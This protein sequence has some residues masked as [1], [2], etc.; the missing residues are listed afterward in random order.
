MF[1]I[2]NGAPSPLSPAEIAE[3]QAPNTLAAAK[4]DRLA[5][6]ADTR[7]QRET[8]GI[9]LNG[10]AIATD[11]QSQALVNGALALV[12]AD[13]SRLIDWKTASGWTRLDAATVAGIAFAVGAHVQACFSRERQLAEAI[14]AA[15]DFAALDAIDLAAGWPG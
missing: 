13:P 9:T 6:L 2:V 7:W 1:R 8:G 11:R 12:S 5:E 15:A 3:I 14:D 4:T 10:A